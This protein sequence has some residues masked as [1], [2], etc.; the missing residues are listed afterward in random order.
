MSVDRSYLSIVS[1]P[2]SFDHARRADALESCL[3]VDRYRA[4]ELSRRGTPAMF[5]RLPSD[6]CEKV[7]AQL[8]EWGAVAVAV[9][10]RTIG[11]SLEPMRVKSLAM[12]AG[13]SMAWGLVPWRGE[14]RGLDATRIAALVRAHVRANVGG[15]EGDF[16][17]QGL[18]QLHG[19]FGAE[20]W[21]QGHSRRGRV[22]VIEVLDIHT[23][24]G[25]HFRVA[26]DKF[27][28]DG[29]VAKVADTARENMDALAAALAGPGRVGIDVG[30]ESARFLA[31]FARDFVPGDWRDVGG[32]SV[33]SSWAGHIAMATR[34][35]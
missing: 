34:A 18:H 17:V 21:D 33:Y 25:E 22:E 16:G 11:E 31:E 29:A 5:G 3:S 26:G 2:A 13:P 27:G 32:F 6:Q 4:K 23:I 19:T 14:A 8:R 20:A 24:D 12:P 28:F 9:S 10:G 15:G 1:W 35:R 7:A 30:F